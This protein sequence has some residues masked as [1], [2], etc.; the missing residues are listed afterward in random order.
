LPISVSF[1]NKM[2]NLERCFQSN[3]TGIPHYGLLGRIGQEAWQALRG[4][5]WS[6]LSQPPGPRRR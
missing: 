2:P 4:L 1:E 6:I 3:S 5:A